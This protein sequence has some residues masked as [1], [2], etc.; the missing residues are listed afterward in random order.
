[1][2]SRLTPGNT[3]VPPCILHKFTPKKISARE[4]VCTDILSAKVHAELITKH[5]ITTVHFV[6]K[7]KQTCYMLHTRK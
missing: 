1:M 4:H 7:Y 2:V 6:V 3:C 5:S